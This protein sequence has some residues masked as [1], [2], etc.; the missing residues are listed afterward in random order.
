MLNQCDDYARGSLAANPAGFPEKPR[1]GS[2]SSPG[3]LGQR[4]R[5][6]LPPKDVLQAWPGASTAGSGSVL[7]WHELIR[8]PEPG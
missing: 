1:T 2:R 7:L 3:A 4:R 8:L 5:V 6:G